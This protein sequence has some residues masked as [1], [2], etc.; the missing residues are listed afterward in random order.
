MRLPAN[1][2]SSKKQV[3]PNCIF[4]TATTAVLSLKRPLHSATQY[5][6]ISTSFTSG[7]EKSYEGKFHITFGITF[8]KLLPDKELLNFSF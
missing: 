3:R 1:Q 8:T 6:N 2:C 7:E 5:I 4:G